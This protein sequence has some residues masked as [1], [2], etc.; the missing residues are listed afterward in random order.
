MGRMLSWILRDYRVLSACGRFT[1]RGS[2][3][4]GCILLGSSFIGA[5]CGLIDEI[6][7]LICGL[8]DE[9]CVSICGL[10]NEICVLICGLMYEIGVLSAA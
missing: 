1:R 5:I 10:M 3:A 6:G 4:D 9:I 2:S 7:V 8:I